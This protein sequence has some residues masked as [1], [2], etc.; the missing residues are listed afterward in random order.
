[1]KK[2]YLKQNKEKPVIRRH[3][4][5]F[6]GA[7]QKKDRD[8]APGEIVSVCGING[9]HL[10]YGY[11][12]AKT[13]IAVR[14][15]S[16][17]NQKVDADYLRG[18][19]HAAVEK[20]TGSLLLQNTDSCRLI[21]SE[22]D[23]LPGLI[24]DSY[25]RHLVMQS[26]TRGIERMKNTLV[27][28][29]IDLLRPESIYERSEHEGRALEGMKPVQKQIYGTTPAEIVMHE[30]DMS[31]LVNVREGQKTGF[32]L[33]QRDNRQLVRRLARDADVLN[34]F[35][36]TG[37]FSV[38]AA[39]GCARKTV[40]VDASSDALEMARKNMDRNHAKT[41][42]GF[43]KADVFEFLRSGRIDSNLVII[44]P[45]ALAKTRAS[46]QSACR[47]YKD[48]HLQIAA[49][50]PKNSLILTCS[51]S[52]FI[53]MDLFQMLIF[54]A[55]ADAGRGASIIGKYYQPCDHPT[56]IFCP[57]TEYL[58]TILLRLD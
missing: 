15:L 43:I 37:G 44:D 21:F 49:T 7:I 54:E 52:R 42:A 39:L 5:I 32:Y 27:T 20:R 19:I 35:S 48:L 16:F 50:C 23:Y 10:G 11:Y 51:C 46:I 22:G 34:L 38:A 29:L 57:E 2:I 40:S 1:M 6:S 47:G 3:P 18:L 25:A 17:G 9:M 30:N 36:Y 28:I 33:D 4:W 12:N 41:S 55:F 31:F 14:L 58:K 53:N 24:V 26:V 13:P 45:P 8:I 56:S